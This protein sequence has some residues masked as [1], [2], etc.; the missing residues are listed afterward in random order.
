MTDW[1]IDSKPYF[2]L[3]R[4]KDE[5]RQLRWKEDD[6]H[7]GRPDTNRNPGPTCIT[8]KS[9]DVLDLFGTPKVDNI[10]ARCN[11]EETKLSLAG[12]ARE[13]MCRIGFS[14]TG[15]YWKPKWDVQA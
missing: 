6:V 7:V 2:A 4:R 14:L 9:G 12:N 10:W 11:H 8:A 3:G 13:V 1:S 5:I 15:R